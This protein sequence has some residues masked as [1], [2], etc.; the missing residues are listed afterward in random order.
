M[1]IFLPLIYALIFILLIYKIKF[2]HIPGF[3]N[4][5]LASVFILKLI[6]GIA[7]WWVYTYYYPGGDMQNYFSDGNTLFHL[8]MQDPKLFSQVVFENVPYD[9]LHIWN[10][11][12]EPTLYNDARTM[13]LLNM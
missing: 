3:S 1:Q 6:A 13:S 5:A 7:V 12:F 11:N 10:S 2:F 4:N 8:L 9:K